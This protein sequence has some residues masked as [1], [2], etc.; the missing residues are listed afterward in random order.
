MISIKEKK[1]CCGC[2]GCE[3]ICPKNSI[4][5]IDDNEG[6]WYPKVNEETCIN[7]GLCEKVC[8]IIQ[9][10]KKVDNIKFL[11]CKN[12][13]IEERIESS[14]GGV[15]SLLT[16]KVLNS[17]GIVFGAGYNENLE[18]NYS[19]VYSVEK[20]KK[21]RGSKYAQ[22]KVGNTYTEA[23]EFLE[24]G[25][26][27]IF[28]GTPCHIAGLKKFL[29]REYEKLLLVDIACHGVPSPLVFKRYKEY[30]ANLVGSKLKSISFRDKSN[31]WKNYK[32][33][34]KFENKIE[35][36]ELASENYYMKG[37]LKDIYLRPSCY[38]CKFKKP[39]TEAD[40]TLAD[41]WGVQNIHLEFDDDKGTSL[42]LVNTKKGQEIM[43]LISDKMDI[44][45]TDGEFAISNN[46]CIVKA[47]KYNPK[48]EK[49]FEDFD[50]VDL[51][52]NIKSN[53][54]ISLAQKVKLKVY[55]ILSRVKRLIKE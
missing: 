19:C 45:E 27:V 33:K 35:K 26:E 38:D 23:K 52:E 44:I 28:T 42:V 40:L 22:S 1:E 31:G 55:S 6:F 5:M 10:S 9:N 15:F 48:R 24:Q 13:E 50:K 30:L 34:F 17:N 49:F 47:V 11:A 36:L 7:C 41:Y 12:K 25:K 16:E 2:Y 51:I 53:T 21:F 32:L 29:G 20:S 39:F 37:F 14:S 18:V 3:N 8:P 54:K 4:K 46:P 43:N